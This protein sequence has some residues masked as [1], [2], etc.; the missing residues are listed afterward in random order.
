MKLHAT[1]TNLP[2]DYATRPEFKEA[3]RAYARVVN[4]PSAG[5]HAYGVY[6]Q[7]FD[8][9][10]LRSLVIKSSAR[11]YQFFIMFPEIGGEDG[12]KLVPV[13]DARWKRDAISSFHV[14][15][16]INKALGL[17]ATET[18]AA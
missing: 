12:C 13:G 6:P 16:A 8:L 1:L 2:F 11:K 14:P 7:I 5:P 4:S 9:G 10:N 3:Y 15:N 18:V 17:L